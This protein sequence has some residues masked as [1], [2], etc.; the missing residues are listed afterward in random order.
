MSSAA[1]LVIPEGSGHLS[2]R[3]PLNTTVAVTES[4]IKGHSMQVHR[5]EVS[6]ELLTCRCSV[7][8]RKSG[9]RTML[10]MYMYIAYQQTWT[11]WDCSAYNVSCFVFWYSEWRNVTMPLSDISNPSF[12]QYIVLHFNWIFYVAPLS[13]QH[14]AFSGCGWR[15]CLQLYRVAVNILNKQSRTVDKGWSSGLC[16]EHGAKDCPPRK[17]KLVSKCHKV[18]RSASNLE[19][20]FE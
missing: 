20:V 7:N 5:C 2:M 14:G 12:I 11:Y 8:K 10:I 17:N 1:H 4:S 15:D 19:V 3:T 6:Q 13:S 16:V 18:L 9:S